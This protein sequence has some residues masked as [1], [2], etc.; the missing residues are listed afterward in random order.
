MAKRDFWENL[1]RGI[2]FGIEKAKETVEHL[3]DRAEGRLDLRAARQ[4]VEALHEKLGA[5][6]AARALDRPDDASPLAPAVA[7]L[8]AAEPLADLL[9]DLEGARAEL[10]AAEGRIGSASAR[11]AESKDAGAEGDDSEGERAS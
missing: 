5:A 6:L 3:T 11:E 10:A 7:E 8:L 9:R 4:R 2:G 1:G